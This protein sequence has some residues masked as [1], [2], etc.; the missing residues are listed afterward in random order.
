MKTVLVLLAL[1]LGMW[2][3]LIA[4]Y[5]TAEPPGGHGVPHGEFTSM[6]RGGPVSSSRIAF[7]GACFGVLEIAVFVTCMTLGI[8][9]S[10]SGRGILFAIFGT[11]TVAYLGVFM[12]MVGAQ[13]ASVASGEVTFLGPFPAATSWMLFG[14]WGA[15]LLFVAAYLI[16]FSRWII[17]DADLARFHELANRT[18]QVE[19][20]TTV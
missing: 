13:R 6:L 7:L 3:V 19:S 4:A 8:S 18:N 12:L 16:G 5:L 14:M 2:V 15:P 11:G 17:T 1:L 10:R 9:R 20:E